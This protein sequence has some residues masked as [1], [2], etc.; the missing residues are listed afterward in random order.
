[1]VIDGILSYPRIVLDLLLNFSFPDA[2]DDLH[3]VLDIEG[4][5]G[6][7]DSHHLYESQLIYTKY[8]GQRN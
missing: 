6:D 7:E 2:H 3:D 4:C 1:L 5:K 8:V